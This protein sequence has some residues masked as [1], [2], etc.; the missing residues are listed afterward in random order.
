M[1]RKVYLA[2]LV[3]CCMATLQISPAL[4]G[5][6]QQAQRLIDEGKYKQAVQAFTDIIA[7]NPKV[8][9]GYRGRAEALLMLDRY[10]D[11]LSD[12]SRLVAY[13]LPSNPNAVNDIYLSY[14]ARLAKKPKDLP[15]LTGAC[16]VSIVTSSPS[17]EISDSI[18]VL[19]APDGTPV[20]GND[21]FNGFY[22]GFDWTASKPGTYQLLATSFE[23][24]GTG[25]LVVSR[26]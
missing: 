4:A 20:F 15:T 21:D 7:Q 5:K 10:A 22:A 16:F 17:G 6:S 13:V 14:D 12:Y 26:N 11:A 3:L 9:D 25:Q 24:I 2:V 8:A 23:G 18:A 1:I 19:L